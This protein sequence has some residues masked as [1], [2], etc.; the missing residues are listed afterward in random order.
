M[1][2]EAMTKKL[3]ARRALPPPAQRRAI[4][5]AAGASQADLAGAL[6]VTQETVSRWERG[7][8]SPSGVLVSEYVELLRLLSR[9]AL[10]GAA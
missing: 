9:E 8:R 1:D 7:E 3:H 10:D 4:R 5:Q 6:G 2:P